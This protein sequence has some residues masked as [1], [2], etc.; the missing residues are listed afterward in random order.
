[1][2]PE[3]DR[4]AFSNITVQNLERDLHDNGFDIFHPFHPKWYNESLER[5]N[6]QQQLVCLPETGTGYLIGNTK[7]LWPFFKAWYTLQPP[8]IPDPF[9]KF[10]RECIEKSLHKS[11][12]PSVFTIFWECKKESDTL[13]SMQRVASVSG[14]AYHDPITQ[15]TVHPIYGTWNSYRAVVIIHADDASQEIAPP[16]LVP[17]LLS[18]KEKECAR[19]AMERALQVSDTEN[20]CRQLHGGAN[21]ANRSTVCKAWIAMRDCVE[22]GRSEYR[23]DEDQ[24]MYHYTKDVKFLSKTSD[25][26]ADDGKFACTKR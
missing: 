19:E 9:D 12:S 7:H 24:L 17:C 21:D 18:T 14:F 22:R 10:C 13:V 20:L 15:L 2:A 6:L 11:Y 25:D 23:F 4:K 26:T 8:S 16:Q 3:D 5:D 1:M